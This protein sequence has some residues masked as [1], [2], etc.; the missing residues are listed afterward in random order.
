MARLDRPTKAASNPAKKFLNW[1]SNEKCFSFY[2]KESQ[3][4]VRVE[5]PL[6]VLFLEHYHT[7][8]GWN[9]ASESG[10]FSNEV[11]SIGKEPLS[12]K[13]FK[14]GEIASGLYK[15]IKTEI[16]S[17]GA[18]YYRSIYVMTETGELI[19]LQLKGSAVSNYSNFY[20]DNNHLL[21]NQWIEVNEFQEGKSGAVSYTVP[22][23]KVGDFLTKEQ[24][25]KADDVVSVLQ[26]YVN[27]YKEAHNSTSVVDEITP[28]ETVDT[29]DIGEAPNDLPF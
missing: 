7:V 21:D 10:I 18:V 2:D 16:K 19:N 13:S 17:E 12:V 20:N 14:G 8:K 27:E 26:S 9:N 6:K 3:Q 1:K 11:Y 29:Q 4:N 24:N 23:F 25:L 28:F 5:L 22:V 15:E